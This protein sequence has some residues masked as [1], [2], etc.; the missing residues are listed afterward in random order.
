[1]SFDSRSKKKFSAAHHPRKFIQS[2]ICNF[3]DDEIESIN[4]EYIVSPGFSETDKSVI[5]FIF[6]FHTKNIS[7]KQLIKKISLF[8][9]N[10]I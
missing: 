6:P 3:I 4:Y 1:M 9:Q 5:N 2:A 10:E 8:Y 7:L